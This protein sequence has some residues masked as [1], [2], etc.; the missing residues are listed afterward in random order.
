MNNN[1]NNNN[2]NLVSIEFSVLEDHWVK[3]KETEK[4]DKFLD[5]ARELKKKSRG[6]WK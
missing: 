3:I 5:L 1:N 4:K 2:N 6:K